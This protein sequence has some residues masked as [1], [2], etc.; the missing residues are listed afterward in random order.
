LSLKIR[1]NNNIKGITINNYEHKISQFAD[2][3]TLILDGTKTSLDETLNILSEFAIIS[4]LKVNFEKTK[5]VWIG[6]KKFSSDSIKTRWKLAWNQSTFR[7]LGIDFH[8]DLT[9]MIHI[10][11]S[12]K[13]INVRKMITSWKRRILTPIGKITVIKS[14]L[15]PIFNQI[16]TVLPTPPDNIIND[17]N[18]IF[19]DFIWQGTV[20]IK[21]EVLIQDYCDGG[22]K[23]INI[24]AFIKALKLTWLRRFVK[25]GVW[26]NILIEKVELNKLYNCGKNYVDKIVAKFKNEFW[27]DVFKAY[28]EFTEIK[29][30]NQDKQFIGNTPLFENHRIL[31][32][33]KSLFLKHWF[34][35]GVHFISDLIHFPVGEF[36]T[37]EELNDK[38]KL[39]TN[40]LELHGIL[41]AVKLFL[42]QNNSNLKQCYIEKPNYPSSLRY[43]TKE[44][45]GCKSMYQSF[46][47]K[48][49]NPTSQ[50][51]WS[52]ILNS[53]IE[54]SDWK[55]YYQ[56]PFK[57]TTDTSIQ[58][59]QVRILHRI[60]G[61]NYLL[62]KMKIKDN[63]FC[64]FCRKELETI[65]HI[66]WECE[67]SKQL[68]KSLKNR[69]ES[70]PEIDETVAI[71]GF[72]NNNL[73][74]ENL[75]LTYTKLYLYKSKQLLINPTMD[76][77]KKF[78]KLYYS[79]NK[80]A[81][82]KC[83]KLAEFLVLWKYIDIF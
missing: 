83:N 46:N 22:L 72:N 69:F 29:T 35:V 26:T 39:K 59:F 7:M 55:I 2:D 32:G 74:S 24:S 71:F 41:N 42:K 54:P 38:Y 64:T 10:N 18:N 13:I 44:E 9:K 37:I 12:E 60:I 31:V 61:T 56:L 19:F 43:I 6:R 16:F 27:K 36:Y 77:L 78:L 11:Y 8:V 14:L 53:E 20:K 70:L 40:F 79:Y 67:R 33:N 50:Q 15:L 23:M 73:L 62:Y 68:Y 5:V 82:V 3:T 21:H 28:S 52:V 75:L 1:N 4:G 65:E 66:F 58:W 34:D 47:I 57:I 51:K 17:I 49:V 25:G 63:P 30:N 48:R 76:G 80:E 81:A 45:K